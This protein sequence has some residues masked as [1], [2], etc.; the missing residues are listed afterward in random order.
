MPKNNKDAKKAMD[1]SFPPCPLKNGSAKMKRTPVS[2]DR[3][4]RYAHMAVLGSG[5]IAAKLPV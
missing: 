4:H 1:P 5:I 3:V 2:I